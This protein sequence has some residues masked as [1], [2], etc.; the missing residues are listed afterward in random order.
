MRSTQDTWLGASDGKPKQEAAT[1]TRRDLIVGG[2][3]AAALSLAGGG[4]AQATEARSAIPVDVDLA[5]DI[6]ALEHIWSRCAGSDR[7]AIT[8]REPWRQDLDRFRREVGLER[9]RFHGIF[10]DELGVFD[11]SGLSPGGP[12]PNFQNID[13]V[14]DGLLERGVQP[15]VELS[16]M[17]RKLAGG[18]ATFGLY[19][20][21]VT[22]PASIEQ[23]SAFIQTFIHHLVHRYGAAEVRQWYFEVW[24][25]PN[26]RFFWSGSQTQYFRFYEA[27]A[28]A[29]RA[30]D[31]SLRVGGPATSSVQ[32]I[33]QF[34]EYCARSGAPLD[35]VSTHCYAGDDQAMM[36]GVAGKYKQ[37]DVIPAAVAQVRAQID[38]TRY[39]GAELWLS[40]WS[41]DSPAMIAHVVA[42]CLPWCHAMSHWTLSSVYEELYVSPFLFKEGDNGFGMLAQR[43]ISKSQFNTYKLMHR[44]GDRR[45]QT[46]GP[47]LASRTAGGGAAILMWNLADVP[48]RPGIPG[49]SMQRTVHGEPHR[50][51]ITLHGARLGRTVRVSYVDQVRGSPLPQWRK[52]GSPQYPTVAQLAEIR[53]AAEMTAP[54]TH[55]LGPT[56][57][58]SL[59]LPP[60]GVALL[61]LT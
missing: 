22:P 48:Q 14:Y 10:A 42:H 29:V 50:Y 12:G 59:E 61:E 30:V 58:L 55:S 11:P 27:T 36:F 20:A 33:P 16:F 5:R 47:A 38:A 35:F 40:E 32:W 26:L 2:V 24:N 4:R 56:G 52:L 54:E 13:V 39:R 45:L 44:L 17:P 25:E 49:V 21:N 57:I 9:V 3:T 15:Y 37:N 23:W 7:A 1:L 60:E 28:R 34:L 46:A 41:S 51:D 6:G 8:M 19:E 43:S 18:R 53:H 31:P